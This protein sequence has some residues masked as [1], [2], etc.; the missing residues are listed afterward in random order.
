MLKRFYGNRSVSH[1]GYVIVLVSFLMMLVIWGSYYAFG[2]FFKPLLDEFGWSRSVTSGAFSLCALIG[3]MLGIPMGGLNDKFG[4]RIVMSFCGLFLGMGY[5]MMSRIGALLHLYLFYGLIMGIGMGGAFVPLLTTVARWFDR[6]RGMMT[7]IVTAGIGIGALIGPPTANW[8]I[9]RY[10]WR[11]A[12]LITGGIVLGSILVLAQFIRLDTAPS[13]KEGRD[14]LHRNQTA[15]IRETKG[16]SF[17]DAVHTGQFWMLFAVILSLGFCVYSTMVHIVAHAVDLGI[18]AA[19]SANILAAIG[20]SSII[21]KILLGKAADIFGSKKIL[22]IGFVLILA[23]M[24]W[25]MP[26]KGVWALY[27]FAVTFGFAYGGCVAAESPIV[28]DLFGLR[29]HGFL[30]GVISFSFTTGGAMGPW[31]TGFIFDSTGSYR[32]AFFV[33]AAV[34]LTGLTFISILNPGPGSRLP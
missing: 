28:A 1:Y 15:Q 26:A 24:L 2:V 32:M 25:I 30:L 31:L 7:G 12:Y 14:V 9:A 13:G 22:I 16:M 19:T 11:V 6:R 34:S 5:L 18:S 17:S 4:P 23:A 20:G 8:L 21:G 10:N 3:G 29:A 33:W 27:T